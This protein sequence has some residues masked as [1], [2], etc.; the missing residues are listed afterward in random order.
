MATIER[1]PNADFSRPVTPAVGERFGAFVG[2]RPAWLKA[3]AWGLLAVVLFWGVYWGYLATRSDSFAREL[4]MAGLGA[5]MTV[6]SAA[7]LAFLAVFSEL[8]RLRERRTVRRFSGDSWQRRAVRVGRMEIPDIV[9]VAASNDGVEWS[10]HTSI[11]FE[12]FAPPR[13][14]SDEVTQHARAVLADVQGRSAGAGITLTDDPC[15]DIVRARVEL[16]RDP[17]G[18]RRAHHI[19]TPAE[20]QYFD[21]LGTTASLDARVD[22]GPSLRE[23]TGAAPQSLSDVERLPA[24]AKMGCGT[25]VVTS[26]D[27]MVL[28]VRG[29]TAIAGSQDAPDARSMV[30]IVAEGVVPTDL[31]DDGRLDPRATAVRGLWE[32]LAIGGTS[33]SVGRITRLV[34]AGMFFDQLRWQPCFAQVAFIDQTW[35]EFHPAAAA[36]RDS[37][38]VERLLSLPFDIGHAGV[39]RL[40]CGTHPDLVLASNHAAAVV[41]LSLLHHHGF[42]DLR[43]ALT[44]PER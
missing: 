1:P 12:P 36:A 5:L 11:E 2:R 33:R 15:V 32:E 30:H 18:R 10:S 35:D 13:T 16:R 23:L 17:S 29:R 43:D 26:D 37:W 20:A 34:D 19:L 9:I 4:V 44:E 7:G 14:M 25:L 22:G 21:F 3:V 8:R 28:G 41:W 42:T 38:E 40:L 24:M 31:G 6:L 27:R 39:R